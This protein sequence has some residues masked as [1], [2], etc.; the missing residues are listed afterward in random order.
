MP[1]FTRVEGAGAGETGQRAGAGAG[2]DRAAQF[3]LAGSHDAHLHEL[4]GSGVAVERAGDG[5]HGDIAGVT[6]LEIAA[7]EHLALCLRF[8]RA[9]V[10]LGEEHAAV[11]CGGG[12][13][14]RELDVERSGGVHELSCLRMERECEQG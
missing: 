7:S 4:K 2:D 14:G 6:G 12:G 9:V 3:G 13:S 8:E 11:R 5:L 10:L 1:A